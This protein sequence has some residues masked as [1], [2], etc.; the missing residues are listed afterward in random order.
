MKGSG[1]EN[2]YFYN[3]LKEFLSCVNIEK[4]LKVKFTKEEKKRINE[5]KK[6]KRIIYKNFDKNF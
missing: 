6:S 3:S 5:R 4:D 2:Q 1:I